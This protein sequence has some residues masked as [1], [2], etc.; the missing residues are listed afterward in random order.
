M[1]LHQDDDTYNDATEDEPEKKTLDAW[2]SNLS[3]FKVGIV[4]LVQLLRRLLR[5]MLRS[6][7][8]HMGRTPAS[9]REGLAV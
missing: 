9:A 5:S 6:M 7:L 2:P 3:N 4:G 8:G 1:I